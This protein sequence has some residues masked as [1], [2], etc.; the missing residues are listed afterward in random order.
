MFSFWPRRGGERKSGH[1]VPCGCGKQATN[2]G[3]VTGYDCSP[4]IRRRGGVGSG[5]GVFNFLELV[6]FPLVVC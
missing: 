3:L 6:L 4:A 2:D 1:P 5:A